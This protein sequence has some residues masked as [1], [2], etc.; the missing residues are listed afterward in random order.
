MRAEEAE[1]IY[2]SAIYEKIK[3]L[4]PDIFKQIETEAKNGNRKVI[5][6]YD[7]NSTYL[8]E[9]FTKLGYQYT[10]V[11]LDNISSKLCIHW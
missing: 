1:R 6:K 10:V 2:D 9:Y 7:K 8:S 4:L 3:D 11:Y 5:I